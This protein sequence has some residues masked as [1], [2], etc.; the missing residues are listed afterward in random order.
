[1]KTR[2]AVALEEVSKY[3]GED[4]VAALRGV[5]LS[6]STGEFVAVLG[7]GGAGKSTLLNLIAGLDSPSAGRVLVEGRD[8]T[9]LR[10]ATRSDVR[11]REIGLVFHRPELF[12]DLTAQENVACPLEFVG[13]GWREAQ[14]RAEQALAWVPLPATAL[15]RRAAQLSDGERQCVAIARALVTEPHL[16]LADEPTA[17]LDDQAAQTTLEL[18]RRLNA[19]RRLTVVVAT[20][21]A[22]IASHAQRIISLR[23]GRIVRETRGTI[24]IMFTDIVGFAAMTERLGDQRVQ[25]I[26]RGYAAIVREQITAHAG[27]EVKAQGDGFMIAFA[28]PRRAL[29][30]AVAIQRAMAAYGDHAEPVHLRI[31]I[32]GGDAT[33]EAYDFFG[34]TVIVASRIAAV[35]RSGEI[36]ISAFVREMTAS[37]GDFAF[38]AGR[39]VAL[40]GLSG[41]Q[42]VYA[43]DWEGEAAGQRSSR[44][45]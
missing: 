31:G 26:L 34:R 23:A 45:A 14:R 2:V 20:H 32:H 41:T 22:L 9:C 11:L 43:V 39:D 19:E 33:K 7:P 38:D 44:V 1:M 28:S 15:H 8:L 40:K 30:C 21:S 10:D 36:L 25:E 17:Q 6:I 24:T 37:T 16:L 12:A 3:Y 27:L 5:S 42:R 4:S 35:A 18:L 29:R 13:M